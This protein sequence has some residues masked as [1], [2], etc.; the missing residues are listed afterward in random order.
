ALTDITF[1]MMPSTTWPSSRSTAELCF[2]ASWYRRGRK[3]GKTTIVTAPGRLAPWGLFGYSSHPAR[4]PA[5]AAER[6]PVWNTAD[7][8]DAVVHLRGRGHGRARDCRQHGHLQRRECGPGAAAP[9]RRAGSPDPDRREERQAPPAGVL[10]VG[11][12]LPV[13]ARNE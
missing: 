3:D 9:L 10:G 8:E 6:H 5:Y 2:D 11:P 4:K 1:E 7:P 13:V 12:E